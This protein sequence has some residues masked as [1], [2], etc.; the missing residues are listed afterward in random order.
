MLQNYLVCV[1]K[2][3]ME[4]NNFPTNPF[5]GDDPDL[6]IPDFRDLSFREADYDNPFKQ[7]YSYTPKNSFSL[8]FKSPS[9][10]TESP[11]SSTFT[12][13]DDNNNQG[14]TSPFG[15]SEPKDFTVND[16]QEFS[17]SSFSGENS[18]SKT[19]KKFKKKKRG[20]NSADV[21]E[22]N[23][24]KNNNKIGESIL[25]AACSYGDLET[26]KKVLQEQTEEEINSFTTGV[27]LTHINN[28]NNSRH[29]NLL[30]DFIFNSLYI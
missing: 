10:I 7:Q 12:F 9:G 15:G 22:N 2:V 1:A 13:N 17:F 19:P 21:N 16:T 28:N 30:F 27:S 20:R 25:Q 5:E 6:I 29:G 8:D 23:N 3:C 24:N 18:P 11:F 14:P 26:V 4:L